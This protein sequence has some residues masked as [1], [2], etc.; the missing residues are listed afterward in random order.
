MSD[1][2]NDLDQPGIFLKTMM[3]RRHNFMCSLPVA[4]RHRQLY[5]SADASGWKKLECRLSLT[6]VRC[7]NINVRRCDHLVGAG[8]HH[9]ANSGERL[10]DRIATP[11]TMPSISRRGL[12]EAAAGA[13]LSGCAPAQTGGRLIW[14]A[15]G[16]SG[17][18][19][20]LLLPEFTRQTGIDVDVQAIPWTGA[21]E[22]LLTGYAGN[23]LPDVM[24]LRSTW[25]PE[26][27]LVGALAPPR[28]GSHLLDD[29]F[30]GAL[31]SVKVAGR[32]MAIPWTADSWMQF[33]RRDLL[34]DAGYA[35]PPA[36]WNDW[37][38]M[39]QALKRR[40]PDRYATLHLLD[41]PEPLFAFAAQQPAPL[42]RDR[43]TRGNFSSDGFRAA[44]G[45]YKSI[46]DERLSPAITGAEA[47]DTYISFR[48]GWFAI[49]PSDAV[50]IGD[51][52]R[53][54]AAIPRDL[55][56]VA[57]TPGLRGAGNAMARGTSIAVSRTARS[58]GDAWKL[59]DYLC[60]PATQ[61]RIY[62]ITGDLP[63]RP[64]AWRGSAL[65]SD[66]APQ[67]FATQIAQSIAPPAVPEWERIVTEVQLVAEHMVRG[68]YGVD[69]ASIEMD[70]RV[71]R[72]LQKRRWLLDHGRTP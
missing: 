61:R 19:A 63:T 41:W 46:Y 21:H 2:V 49:L 7:V 58:P 15:I 18:N 53:R 57:A 16:T 6:K 64:S 65:S 12:L 5:Q 56:G 62:G 54:A 11:R 71:D 27:A 24:M 25:L 70:K 34:A 69:A 68:D 32:A 22:K 38:R 10:D 45:F 43:N 3:P 17:E 29:Q 4:A 48:S 20:P 40:H 55:W 44:L 33:F 28:P 66:P 8:A 67:S 42:L 37:M 47:G 30:S 60:S 59:V 26:L 72:I 52:R 13:A 36:A 9:K 23:S 39:A 50:A 1:I 51:L 14:W 31:A 35:A